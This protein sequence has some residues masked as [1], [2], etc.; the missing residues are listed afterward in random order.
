MLPETFIVGAC[1]SVGTGVSLLLVMLLQLASPLGW[2]EPKLFPGS[3]ESQ[4][5]LWWREEGEQRASC[6]FV[7][8]YC[9][10]CCQIHRCCCCGLA[11]L[12]WQ[13]SLYLE[14]PV[15]GS[16]VT[17]ARSCGH[18]SHCG[19]VCWSHVCR[20]PCYQVLQ[21][22]G[23]SYYG[24]VSRISATVSAVPLTLPSVCVLVHPHLHVQ[25][26]GTRQ[27][28]GVL[29]QV[30][31]VKLWMFYWLLFEWKRQREHLVPPRC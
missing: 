31:L 7:C 2:Q 14:R 28:P 4:V 21:G 6:I 23:I 24:H 22:C 26:C 19:W 10:W 12:Q 8:L 18:G 13:V 27:H 29:G 20:L 30:I 25:M 5:L 1:A 9:I 15:A 17:A 11:G 3:P 16:A